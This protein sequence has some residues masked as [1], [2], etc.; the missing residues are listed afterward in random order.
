MPFEYRRIQSLADLMI[1]EPRVFPD[2]RGWFTETYKQG[3]F[4]ANGIESSFNQD[5]HSR[6]DGRN[7]IRGLHYQ[8]NPAAQGKLVRCVVGAVFDVA[9]DIRK[10]S[11]TYSRWVSV[12][13][14]AEN[15]RI[16]WIPPGFAHGF[17]TLTEVSEV[18]YKATA[19]Y[20]AKHD[21]CIRWDDPTLAINWPLTTHPLL[22]T[23]D[24]SAPA[25]AQAENNFEWTR[26]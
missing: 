17:C 18:V 20:S 14:T 13:L 24:A 25:L 26:S 5:N 9:V 21:R 4:A 19:E 3:D 15:R 16:L 22:S 8:L 11:P 12:E 7:V 6:T 23:R 2:D 1:I 10:G